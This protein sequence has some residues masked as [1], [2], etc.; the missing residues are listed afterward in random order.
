MTASPY[1]EGRPLEVDLPLHVTEVSAGTGSG[2]TFVMLHGFGASSF[3]WR[4]WAPRLATR[5]RVLCV[6]YKGFGAAPKPADDRY[7]PEDQAELILELID[8][9]QPD[10]LTLVGHSL[11]GGIALLAAQRLCAR[12]TSPLERLVLVSSPAYRQ[13]LP[14]FVP[15]SKRPALARFLIRAVGPRRL[16]RFVIRSIVKDPDMVD[17]ETVNAYARPLMTRGGVD[18]MLATGQRILPDNIDETV[19]KIREVDV[20]SLLIWG[21]Y[22]RVVPV[23][24]GKRLAADLPDATMIV[25]EGCGHIPPEEKPDESFAFLAAFLDR[26]ER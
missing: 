17:A 7:T 9:L 15:L 8:Q 10:R 18:S 23:W 24:V 20:P 22:E 3:T 26:T 5:G 19:K 12:P 13:P 6:D 16:V 14:P 21:D 1:I 25:L 11:G 2:P 4:Y